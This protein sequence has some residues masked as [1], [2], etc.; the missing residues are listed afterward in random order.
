MS[1]VLLYC[2]FVGK[3]KP[4]KFYFRNSKNSKEN[5]KMLRQC[6]ICLGKY[7]VRQRKSYKVSCFTSKARER[8]I[9]K[10]TLKLPSFPFR[11]F[12]ASFFGKMIN[13]SV[14]KFSNEKVVACSEQPLI[15]S[16]RFS[17]IHRLM[18]LGLYQM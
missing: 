11:C 14:I 8:S 13:F 17:L 18:V 10:P 7:I 4:R 9:G 1:F 5:R 3:R 16:F 2:V 15:I 12:F 6:Q